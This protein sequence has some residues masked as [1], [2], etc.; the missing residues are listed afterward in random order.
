MSS[1]YLSL[2]SSVFH[3]TVYILNIPLLYFY[4]GMSYYSNWYIWLAGSQGGTWLIG[5]LQV[6][7]VVLLCSVLLSLHMVNKNGILFDA[8]NYKPLSRNPDRILNLVLYGLQ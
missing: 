4:S 6:Q 2:L 5:G 3:Y 1:L 7:S 8:N